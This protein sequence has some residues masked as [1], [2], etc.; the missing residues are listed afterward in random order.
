MFNVLAQHGEPTK[1]WIGIHLFSEWI[2][3]NARI[4]RIIVRLKLDRTLMMDFFTPSTI[5]INVCSK[6]LRE[7][8]FHELCV[9]PTATCCA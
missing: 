8:R 1:D 2:S 3:T 5:Q 7:Q 4:Y 6:K 9:P